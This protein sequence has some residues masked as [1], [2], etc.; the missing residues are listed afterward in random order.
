MNASNEK[1]RVWKHLLWPH[2]LTPAGLAARGLLI[3]AVFALVHLAGLGPYTTVLSGTSPGGAPLDQ[4]DCILG[5]AYVFFWLA[6]TIVTPILLLAAGLLW[7]W[8]RKLAGGATGHN[9]FVRRAP[10]DLT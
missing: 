10:G 1:P 9:H 6:F 4:W 3:A 5:G 8:E 7:A 2:A